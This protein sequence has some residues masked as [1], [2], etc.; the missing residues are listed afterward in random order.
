[1]SETKSKRLTHFLQKR[2]QEKET[3]NAMMK[4]KLITYNDVN[5]TVILAFPIAQW[6]L[7]PIGNM[8]GGMI[9]VAFDIAMACIAYVTGNGVFT[10]TIQIAINFVHP[11]TLGDTLLI[12]AICDHG[13]S[14]MAQVRGIAK[15]Q[16]SGATIA[17]ANGSYVM[18]TR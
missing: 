7:N 15:S 2:L 3:I 13:G 14:R 5:K 8:H 17:S 4:M 10:P 12:E 18:N 6:Q 9:A 1:M 11:I 16:K